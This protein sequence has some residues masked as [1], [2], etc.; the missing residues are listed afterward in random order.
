MLPQW[1]QHFSQL[2][3]SH[4][5]TA[6][7][8]S[9]SNQRPNNARPPESHDNHRKLA[10]NKRLGIRPERINNRSH[11]WPRHNNNG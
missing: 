1:L 8:Q 9:P 6:N 10:N 5:K 11:S 3:P 4:N 7:N 2:Q